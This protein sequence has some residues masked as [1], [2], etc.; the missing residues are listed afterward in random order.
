MCLGILIEIG[1]EGDKDCYHGRV[2]EYLPIV[3]LYSRDEL[4]LCTHL[5]FHTRIVDIAKV[6][7]PMNKYNL[8][9]I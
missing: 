1:R 2:A 5:D 3:M 4:T 7:I 6:I 8:S 9:N